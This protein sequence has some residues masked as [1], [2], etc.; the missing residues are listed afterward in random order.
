MAK[1]K[2]FSGQV[3]ADTIEVRFAF[4]GKVTRVYK[5]PGDQVKVGDWLASLDRK[6]LQIDLDREL[7]DYERVR[8][9]FEIFVLAHP[10][11]GND[12][13]KYEKI[14]AQ[15]VLN[16][17]VKAVELAKYQLDNADMKSPTAGVVVS[18]GGLRPGL[19]VTPSSHPF[20]VLD[21]ASI[22]FVFEAGWDDLPEFAPGS[23]VKVKLIGR[24][25]P[26]SGTILPLVPHSSPASKS[27]PQIR[28][29]LAESPAI[30]PGLPGEVL[31]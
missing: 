30:L 6:V 27:R 11:P 7:A 23:N 19:F 31:I 9:E 4:S 10:N 25:D 2:K 16:S 5:H 24:P 21:S 13:E 12:R 17:A 3:T 22:R 29:G 26:V 18:D 14:Q 28:V 20:E 8:A 1:A 15:S